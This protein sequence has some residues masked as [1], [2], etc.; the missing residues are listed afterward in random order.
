MRK[1]R[2][3][4]KIHE[5]GSELPVVDMEDG[6]KRRGNFLVVGLHLAGVR[7]S[8]AKNQARGRNTKQR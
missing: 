5:V 2:R 7:D 8:K 6:R 1:R 4:N 3:R